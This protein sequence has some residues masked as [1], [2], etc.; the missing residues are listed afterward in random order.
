MFAMCVVK[1]W[2]AVP[3]LQVNVMSVRGAS[4]RLCIEI[5]VLFVLEWLMLISTDVVSKLITGVPVGMF[6]ARK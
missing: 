5:V 2:H 3:E 4:P 6:S 1:D